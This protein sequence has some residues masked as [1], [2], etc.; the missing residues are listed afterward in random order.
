MDYNIDT[1]FEFC[2][3]DNDIG[4]TRFIER[5]N[6]IINK[7][8]VNQAFKIC[9]KFNN[10][11]VI[12]VLTQRKGFEYIHDNYQEL[13]MNATKKKFINII[14]W[15]YDNCMPLRDLE[16]NRELYF[17]AFRYVC[18]NDEQH[19][20][21]SLPV[22]NWL[23][24]KINQINPIFIRETF[25]ECCNNGK[26]N[27]IGLLMTKNEITDDL[28]DQ[29][30]TILRGYHITRGSTNIYDMAD[31]IESSFYQMAT[32]DEC[33]D[34]IVLAHESYSEVVDFNY[35]AA[36]KNACNLEQFQI[37]EY[38]VNIKS[39]FEL[40]DSAMSYQVEW[41]QMNVARWLMTRMK[42]YLTEE[43]VNTIANE[44]FDLAASEGDENMLQFLNENATITEE[45]AI[46]SF[47]TACRV[48]NVIAVRYIYENFQIP[49]T[50]VREGLEIVNDMIQ[51]CRENGQS[52]VMI[53][54]YRNVKTWL[55]SVINTF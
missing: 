47:P 7:K 20:N 49:R 31:C 42:T 19:L 36:F 14:K 37:A 50:E 4:V 46:R 28:I 29:G 38:I 18:L 23:Y 35:I 10:L 16:I 2:K 1:F 34:S 52:A 3:S 30:E 8:V 40:F 32:S 51:H 45:T 55:E 6:E 48:N 17:R 26:H 41:K 15:L 25:F 11:K 9:F 43:E 5:R 44:N 21:T 54:F 24:N 12:R 39:S 13:F 53:R 22:I 27:V 33:L